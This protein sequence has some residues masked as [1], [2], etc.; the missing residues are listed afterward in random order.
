MNKV[1]VLVAVILCVALAGIAFAVPQDEKLSTKQK[2]VLVD[3]NGD[4]KIDGVDIYD[5]NGKVVKRGY[6]TN[7]D[8]AIDRWET[9]DPNSGMPIVT[10]SDKAFE[11][12]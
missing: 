6:D 2:V 10:E 1:I 4:T 11:L 8:Q 9:V 3:R 7:G 12:R 5:E